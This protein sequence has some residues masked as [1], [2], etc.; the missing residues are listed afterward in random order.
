M[1]KLK[2]NLITDQKYTLRLNTFCE[3]FDLM[4]LVICWDFGDV[5]CYRVQY[6]GLLDISFT[7]LSCVLQVF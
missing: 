2:W 6:E 4:W 1:M 5:R 7:P 3:R